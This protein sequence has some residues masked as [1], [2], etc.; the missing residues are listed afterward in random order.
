MRLVLFIM[1]FFFRLLY[2]QFAWAYDLVA[3]VVSLGRWKDWVKSALPH[4]QGRVLEIGYG[5]G[6]LQV[7]MDEKGLAAYGV[8]ESHQIAHQANRR[9]SRKG[10]SPR[11]ARGYAQRLPFPGAT[12]D[13]VVATFPAEYI[14]DPL[15]LQEIQR[16]LV[17][18]G[19]LVI[20]PAA[21]IT[22][23]SLPER[24]AAGLFKVTGQAGV[25]DVVIATIKKRLQAAGFVV[26]H[27]LV[28]FPGSRVLVM[29]ASRWR[30]R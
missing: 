19:N 30:K 29:I 8:D 10:L 24:L 14:F 5:P 15:T 28:E 26:R 17:V 23:K 18:G 16:V 12:F 20:V 25:M 2:H 7:S 4:L 11:L 3:A 1:G 27:E 6:H 21:W 13:T 9:L 22:G